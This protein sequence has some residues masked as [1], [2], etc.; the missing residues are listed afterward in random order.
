MTANGWHICEGMAFENRQPNIRTKVDSSTNAQLLPSAVLLQ[1]CLL[2]PVF[3]F[4]LSILS[5]KI[6]QSL[7]QQDIFV[8]Y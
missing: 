2:A 6:V 4:V 8:L 7:S 1:I 3:I 5:L